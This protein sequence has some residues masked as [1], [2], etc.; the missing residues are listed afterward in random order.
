MLIN[1]N[2]FLSLR[3][4][5]FYD[6]DDSTSYDRLKRYMALFMVERIFHLLFDMFHMLHAMHFSE[7]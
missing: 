4:S 5:R 1:A 7:G 6:L 2:M 3:E